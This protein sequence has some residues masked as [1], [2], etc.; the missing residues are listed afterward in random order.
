MSQYALLSL[1]LIL[2]R[3]DE[4]TGERT[5]AADCALPARVVESW[6][7]LHHGSEHRPVRPTRKSNTDQN[8]QTQMIYSD[9]NSQLDLVHNTLHLCIQ[10]EWRNVRPAV[11]SSLTRLQCSLSIQLRRRTAIPFP[12]PL[13]P[14]PR[15]LGNC[16][17]LPMAFP[18]ISG[19][20]DRLQSLAPSIWSL[21]S[22]LLIIVGDLWLLYL[23][24]ESCGRSCAGVI[25]DAVVGSCDGSSLAAGRL[26]VAT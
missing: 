23:G 26:E 20:S 6:F 10:R 16:C 2:N 3:T 11:C 8:I 7:P 14:L 22:I 5:K 12:T 21:S 4:E 19:A 17:Y 25:V 24:G 1:K 13:R 15:L 18:R 9:P